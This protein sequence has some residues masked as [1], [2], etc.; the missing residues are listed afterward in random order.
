MYKA[1][2]TLCVTQVAGKML[3]E[4]QLTTTSHSGDDTRIILVLV[5]FVVVVGAFYE[6]W[7]GGHHL[8]FWFDERTL[9]FVPAELLFALHSMPESMTSH[10]TM[11]CDQQS[12]HYALSPAVTRPLCSVTS[13]VPE[14]W[15]AQR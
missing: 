13:A 14:L 15:N 8:E 7:S 2:R 12:L 4:D 3:L 1:T 9:V 6:K 11:L 10:S 5:T